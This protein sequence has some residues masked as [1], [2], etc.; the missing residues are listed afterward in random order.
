M[1]SKIKKL[2]CYAVYVVFFVSL[3]FT[4]VGLS[5]GAY[6]NDDILFVGTNSNLLKTP[7]IDGEVIYK[8]HSGEM[9]FF[10]EYV[11]E[12]NAKD[13]EYKSYWA[14]VEGIVSG[15]QGYVLSIALSSEQPY[16]FI[17]AQVV[18]D[19][20]AKICRLPSSETAIANI[21][22]GDPFFVFYSHQRGDEEWLRSIWVP[23]CDGDKVAVHG[24]VLYDDIRY[25]D[26]YEG[27]YY[28]EE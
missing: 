12:A 11:D 21:K 24:W 1:T 19:E 10:V 9:V 18:S 5:E 4:L 22:K 3:L 2:L 13:D 26:L 6:K 17:P 14:I 20:G 8:M 23:S 28:G 15:K 27:D 16:G 7:S 25:I